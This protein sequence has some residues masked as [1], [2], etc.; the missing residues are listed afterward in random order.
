VVGG[1]CHKGA[2]KCLLNASNVFV[3]E[4]LLFVLLL[5]LTYTD[6][7]EVALIINMYKNIVLYLEIIL[8]IYIKYVQKYLRVKTLE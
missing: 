3:V 2:C 5:T 7:K 6:L 8:C 4:L 1:L